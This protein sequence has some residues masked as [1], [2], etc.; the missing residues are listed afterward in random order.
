VVEPTEV[1]VAVEVRCVR[2]RRSPLARALT[3]IS[4]LVELV[5]HGGLMGTIRHEGRVA[6]QTRP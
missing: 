3:L 2:E 6:V 4:V 5:V 1:R